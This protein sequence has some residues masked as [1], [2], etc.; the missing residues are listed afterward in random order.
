MRKKG[1]HAWHL[2]Q[3]HK[4]LVLPEDFQV[5]VPAFRQVLLPLHPTAV[6]L[7]TGSGGGQIGLQK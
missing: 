3:N 2:Q 6:D 5:V 1:H 7:S 4:T